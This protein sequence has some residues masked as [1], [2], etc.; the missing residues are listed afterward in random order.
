MLKPM[1]DRGNI[2]KKLI[3]GVL[4]IA[5]MGAG[6]ALSQTPRSEHREMRQEQRIYS[7]A[8]RGRLTPQEMRKIQRQ[9]H[10]IDRQQ[11]RSTRDGYVSPRERQRIERMQNRASRN[12][13]RKT[14]NNRGY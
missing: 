9:Q 7:G 12:I 6:P 2:M 1:T 11:A 13:A 3:L 5:L 10:R 4:A 8:V 14:H